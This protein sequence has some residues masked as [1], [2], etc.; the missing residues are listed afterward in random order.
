MDLPDLYKVMGTTGSFE[1]G[2]LLY[3][4]DDLRHCTCK[5]QGSWIRDAIGE[6]LG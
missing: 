3:Q 6:R 4:Q 1:T 5:A 2:H